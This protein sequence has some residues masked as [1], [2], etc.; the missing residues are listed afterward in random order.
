MSNKSQ[1]PPTTGKGAK[2]Y[3]R[4]PF[5]KHSV[6]VPANPLDVIPPAWAHFVP[7]RNFGGPKR[8]ARLQEIFDASNG[9]E[10]PRLNDHFL[11]CSIMSHDDA[12]DS[13]TTLAITGFG[14]GKDVAIWVLSNFAG[15]EANMPF[16][17]G[18]FQGEEG[19]NLDADS[20]LEMIHDCHTAVSVP[21]LVGARKQGV[22]HLVGTI[23]IKGDA[24]ESLID[25][26]PEYLQDHV[27]NYQ[28]LSYV[29]DDDAQVV[30]SKRWAKLTKRQRIRH[31]VLKSI[32]DSYADIAASTGPVL[33]PSLSFANTGVVIC[34][35]EASPSTRSKKNTDRLAL[36]AFQV[37]AGTHIMKVQDAVM[38]SGVVKA[39]SQGDEHLIG[40]ACVR[41]WSRAPTPPQ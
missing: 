8:P 34:S 37:F 30:M 7:V 17:Q 14:E 32:L 20:A 18:S 13:N 1:P 35:P 29:Q 24:I 12:D 38:K 19:E 16:G 5:H 36:A 41:Y 2:D 3:T 6:L 28:P 11:M 21:I 31:E 10:E 22:M 27:A 23:G 40:A 15:S 25:T 33:I 26:M 39:Q 4:V 9:K